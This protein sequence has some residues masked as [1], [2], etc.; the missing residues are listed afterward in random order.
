LAPA[1]Y[2]FKE[3]TPFSA[4]ATQLSG[5]KPGGLEHHR[6]FIGSNPAIWVFLGCWHHLSLQSPVATASTG[7]AAR[8][9]RCNHRYTWPMAC[10]QV[11]K[12]SATAIPLIACWPPRPN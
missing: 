3:Q 4:V 10:E 2:L 7:Q 1:V 9:E 6:E 12:A 5:I 8:A 11:A